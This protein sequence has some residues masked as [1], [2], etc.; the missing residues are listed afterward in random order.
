MSDTTPSPPSPSLPSD[1]DKLRQ[2]E[3]A[4]PVQDRDWLK[5]RQKVA[6]LKEPVPYIASVGWTCIGI[7]AGSLLGLLAW[8][9]VNSALPIKARMHYTFMTPLLVITAVAGTVIVTFTFV[10]GHQIKQIHVT[11]VENVLADMDAIY[12]PYSHTES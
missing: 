1:P 6:N 4:F 7:T 2:R 11:T 3:R 9:P 8:I 12:E 10:V 5:L